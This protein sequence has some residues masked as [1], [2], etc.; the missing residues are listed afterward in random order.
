MN[1]LILITCP[2]FYSLMWPL[3]LYGIQVIWGKRETT[4][5]LSAE[6]VLQWQPAAAPY[7]NN[8]Q[9]KK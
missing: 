9:N 5:P 1:L 4:V 7:I 2:Y 8:D 3:G 6:L